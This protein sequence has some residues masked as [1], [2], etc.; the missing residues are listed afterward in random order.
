MKR[1]H[2]LMVTCVAACCLSGCNGFRKM[3]TNTTDSVIVHT[4]YVERIDTAFVTVEKWIQQVLVD[5]TSTLENDYCISR[6]E[7]RSFGMLYHSLETK[8][9]QIPVPVT[10]IELVRDSI[11]YKDKYI[12]IREPYPVEKEF[13]RWQLIRLHG[14]WY[15]LAALVL[16][17]VWICRKPLMKFFLRIVRK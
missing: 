11:I 3:I 17:I 2:L 16:S 1:L 13:T 14:F 8:P 9:Q 10:S 4:E 6:A 7:I 12:E 5:T 15:T